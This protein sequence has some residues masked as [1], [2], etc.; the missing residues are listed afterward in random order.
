MWQ[1]VNGYFAISRC[2]L[3]LL[4]VNGDLTLFPFFQLVVVRGTLLPPPWFSGS[5]IVC[6]F[7]TV[8][9]KR[10]VFCTA[11]FTRPT[12]DGHLM[13]MKASS[14]AANRIFPV[15]GCPLQL[16]DFSFDRLLEQRRVDHGENFEPQ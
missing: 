1:S 2:S 12:A 5:T 4:S 11:V 10:V 15:N 7:S 3:W 13:A 8:V 9:N 6:G 14:L 16:C